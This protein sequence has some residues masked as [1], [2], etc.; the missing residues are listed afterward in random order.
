MNIFGIIIGEISSQIVSIPQPVL[1]IPGRRSKALYELVFPVDV[2]PALA[3]ANFQITRNSSD[4]VHSLKLKSQ[5]K[6]IKKGGE[7]VRASSPKHS[8]TWKEDF[9]IKNSNVSSLKDFVLCVIFLYKNFLSS[10]SHPVKKH[11]DY[12]FF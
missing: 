5:L 12:E 11:F 8:E 2:L 4:D 9:M 6:A 1:G 10:M 7:S 3:I